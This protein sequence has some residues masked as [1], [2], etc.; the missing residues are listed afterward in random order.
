MRIIDTDSELYK[1]FVD[2][3]RMRAKIEL[4]CFDFVEKYFSEEEREALD[5][6]LS[7]QSQAKPRIYDWTGWVLNKATQKSN[8]LFHKLNEEAT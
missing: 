8:A 6:L 2:V 3:V 1:Q 7:A 5:R 4:A